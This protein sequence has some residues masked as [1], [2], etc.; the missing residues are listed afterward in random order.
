MK[1][2]VFTEFLEMVEDRF[3]ADMVD[4]IIDDAQPPSG[5][6]YT[7]VGSYSH[8]E[9]VDL[10]TALSGRCG[11]PVLD[12]VKT[13]GHHLYGRFALSHPQFFDGVPDA[14]QFLANIEE[15]IHPEVR[16]LY[17][18]A[19]L[20]RFQIGH[21]DAQRMELIYISPRH[22]E[23]LAEGL[24]TGCLEHFGEAMRMTRETLGEGDARQERFV[25]ERV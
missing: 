14:F 1:G 15:V 7:A 22:F 24:I 25:L 8:A 9:M 18:D 16:K 2:I 11:V 17:P 3:S 19:E 20:P 13:F 12:L 4:D 6:V 10:V 23:D 21:R 5:G